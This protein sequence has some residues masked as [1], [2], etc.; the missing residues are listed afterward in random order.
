M[1]TL[2]MIHY[3]NDGR[4]I[5]LEGSTKRLLLKDERTA[6]IYRR[7]CGKQNLLAIAA[8][9]KD[10]FCPGKDLESIIKEDFLPFYRKLEHYY[11][12]T[13]YE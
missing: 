13:F 2:G 6:F 12:M 1:R 9:Y 7:S 3:G 5:I 10:H 4:T 11:Y 8:E